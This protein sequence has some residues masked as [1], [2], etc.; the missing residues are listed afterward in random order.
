MH[1]AINDVARK[2]C[3]MYEIFF[4]NLWVIILC[5]LFTLKPKNL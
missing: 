1:V 3:I 2:G 5:L 4:M